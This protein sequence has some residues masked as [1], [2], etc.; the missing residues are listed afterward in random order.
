MRIAQVV[1][2]F[3]PYFGG[4]GNV[5]Y[6]YS[7]RLAARGHD[8]TVFTAK[9]PRQGRW[10]RIGTAKDEAEQREV[11]SFNV[12]RLKPLFRFGNAA[13]LP[14]LGRRLRNFDVV[15]VHYP[16]V[17]AESILGVLKP[18]VTTYHMDLMAAGWKG[19]VFDM[20]QRFYTGRFLEAS[21]K[22]IFTTR[23]YLKN[24]RGAV[25]EPRYGEKFCVLPL[26]VGDEFRPMPPDQKFWRQR[27]I[28]GKEV[29][30]FVGGLDAAHAFKG[31]DVLIRAMK[32]VNR[33]VSLVLVGDGEL[34]GK[35]MA[36]SQALR[37]MNVHFLGRVPKEDLISFYQQA[38]FVVLPS[39]NSSEA[40]GL[41][42]IESFAC[43]RPVLASD[44]PGVRS[45]V[46]PA[47]DGLLSR[48]GDAKDLAQKIKTML[49]L[50]LDLMGQN[51]FRKVQLEYRWPAIID[52]LEGIYKEII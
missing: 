8:V 23:D 44:L 16:F 12:V 40:F 24:G 46:S 45:L 2:T 13:V 26:G 28:K 22:V 31:V 9:Y 21:S 32:Q 11:G 41:V 47:K 5:A 35:Y 36:Q 18:I 49:G 1:S 29:I 39:I 51:G 19:L 38:S 3:P 33:D 30:L 25:Y 6:Q 37:L 15:H 4:M 52:R 7:R 50:N 42:L 48:P 14:G 43:G 20:Y 10:D 27:G 34:K 17:G